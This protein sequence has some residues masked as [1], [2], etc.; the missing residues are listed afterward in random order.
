M[1]NSKYV[2]FS[3]FIIL[4]LLAGCD[5]N[6]FDPDNWKTTEKDGFDLKWRVSG[7]NLEVELEGPSSGWVA[8]G[9]GGSYL[10]HDSNIIIGY[11]NG[12]SVNIRDDFGIDSNT[13]E[14]DSNLQGGEQNVSDKSGSESSGK[15]EIRFTIP[16]D[17]GDLWDVVL[18]EGQ[19]YNIVFICGED[20]ADDFTSAYKTITS[21]SITL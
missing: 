19:S 7:S 13:H 11:V 14:S 9:F 12:S 4:I 2:L 18:S 20:G 5:E 1:F 8:V 15:T 21:K 10:M 3:V 16:L 6:P 17:S